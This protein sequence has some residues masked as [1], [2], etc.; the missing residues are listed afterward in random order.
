MLQ[1]SGFLSAKQI[2]N[3]S[4]AT[5]VRDRILSDRNI[6]CT[7]RG[8]GETAG[9]NAPGAFLVFFVV[10]CP[11]PPVFAWPSKYSVVSFA[12]QARACI[13]SDHSI[14]FI[15]RG[16]R[17][18]VGSNPPWGFSCFSIFVGKQPSKREEFV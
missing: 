9:S 5:Q 17:T 14:F 4:S 6:F 3:V 13:L 10:T 7:L 8:G 2:L 16:G 15:P 11:R 1:T 18:T 12:T